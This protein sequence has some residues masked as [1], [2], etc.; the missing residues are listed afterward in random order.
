[1]PRPELVDASRPPDGQ[2]PPSSADAGLEDLLTADEVAQIV[3]LPTS[4]VYEQ[5]R[6]WIRTRG[7]EGIPTVTLG[8][9]RRYRPD[10]IGSWIRAQEHGA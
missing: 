8:R 6:L 1:M 10:A 5:S 2:S 9:Y 3:K 7:A 4:W